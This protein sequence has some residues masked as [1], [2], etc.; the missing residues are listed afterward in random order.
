MLGL[1]SILRGADT[2]FG[3]ADGGAHRILGAYLHLFS[4]QGTTH[5]SRAT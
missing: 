1:R 5:L 4:N 3:G 2:Q